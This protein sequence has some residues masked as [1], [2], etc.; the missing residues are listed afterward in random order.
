MKEMNQ[1]DEKITTSLN[2]EG[3]M[4]NFSKKDANTGI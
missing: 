1:L 2:G 3:F 4:D